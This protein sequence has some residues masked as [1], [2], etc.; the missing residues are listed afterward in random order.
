MVTHVSEEHTD[1]IFSVEYKKHKQQA[2]SPKWEV[3]R[4]S[5]SRQISI[6]LH[7]VTSHKSVIL[8]T[9]L[10]L[11]LWQTTCLNCHLYRMIPKKNTDLFPKH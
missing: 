6:G 5:R 3:V 11:T 2:Q 7:G 4:S 8:T 9:F 1:P 10:N